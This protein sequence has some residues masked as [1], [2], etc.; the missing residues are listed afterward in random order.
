MKII[1]GIGVFFVILWF[2]LGLVAPLKAENL[3]GTTICG[4][5]DEAEWPPYAYL[6]RENGEK[7][8]EVIGFSVDVVN[9][10][11]SAYGATFEP[12]LIPWKRCLNDVKTGHCDMVM[13]AAYSKDRADTFHISRS[14]YE[15]TPYYFYSKKHYPKGLDIRNKLDLSKFSIGGKLGYTYADYGLTY[16][17][18]VAKSGIYADNYPKL[19]Q[20][21][22]A[23]RI[24]IIIERL[25]VM[26]GFDV[27]GA[28]LLQDKTLGSAPI[29][30]MEPS[31][32]YMM[33]PKNQKGA[34][35]K[36]MADN[37]I[38]RLIKSGRLLELH[39]KYVTR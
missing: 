38:E 8:N 29:P 6:R 3:N 12:K 9:E 14:F 16:D 31:K 22:H 33:F 11:F 34:E 18:I 32:F 7:T 21:L 15:T 26:A 37:G 24:D 25:E 4:C 39:K 20:L 27:T 17:G 2:V 23:G 5:D 35:L 30:Q 28:G 19:I 10:I 36:E 1:N 13:N